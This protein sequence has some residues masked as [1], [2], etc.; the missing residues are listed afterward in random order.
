MTLENTRAPLLVFCL[1]GM[2]AC[3]GTVGAWA[4]L[5]VK[6]IMR[7]DLNRLSDYYGRYDVDG[8]GVLSF[9]ELMAFYYEA[10]ALPPYP[11]GEYKF[12]PEGWSHGKKAWGHYTW[13]WGFNNPG[14]P[15]H[16][17]AKDAVKTLLYHFRTYDENANDALEAEE[18]WRAVNKLGTEVKTDSGNR[19]YAPDWSGHRGAGPG[20]GGSYPAGIDHYKSSNPSYWDNLFSDPKAGLTRKDLNGLI[21]DFYSAD[22]DQDYHLNPQEIERYVHPQDPEPPAFRFQLIIARR[23]LFN[24]IKNFPGI[25]SDTNGTLSYPELLADFHKL[26]SPNRWGPWSPPWVTDPAF[27]ITRADLHALRS[28]TYGGCHRPW[29]WGHHGEHGFNR[30]DTNRDKYLSPWEFWGYA[31]RKYNE[32]RGWS[33]P[34]ES[35]HW[36]SKYPWD[37]PAAKGPQFA[38]AENDIQRLDLDFDQHDANHD[39][40]L[41]LA[42]VAEALK[43]FAATYSLHHRMDWH[44]SSPIPGGVRYP[45]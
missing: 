42:E 7:V 21:A 32:A 2:L 17:L 41:Q 9:A 39:D 40:I 27:G 10:S 1:I 15:N 31:H 20:N 38:L 22:A 6:G 36:G 29:C 24:M 11:N 18:A 3:A 33:Y 19:P 4:E 14:S 13:A 43:A 26:P 30:A 25:D 23:D 12:H 28:P 44:Y 16:G 5:D 8:N 45:Y 37:H 35:V 34:G